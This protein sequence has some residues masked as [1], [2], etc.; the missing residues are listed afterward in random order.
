MPILCIKDDQGKF[1]PVP[2]LKGDP[3]VYV[4]ST[5]PTGDETIWIDPE[6][7]PYF[8][9][10]SADTL[11]GVK[12]GKGLRMDGDAIEVVQE[13]L[14]I[15]ES[16]EVPEGNEVKGYTYRG[17]LKDFELTV[18]IPAASATSG[19]G[20]EVYKGNRKICGYSYMGTLLSTKPT[21]LVANT[22]QVNGKSSFETLF[23][24]H[25]NSASSKALVNP[26][27]RSAIRT[28]IDD[29][30]TSVTIYANAAFPVGTKFTLRGV[31]TD[32]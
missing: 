26:L 24:A 30:Y 7:E 14:E 19:G 31:R 10:A 3:G 12:V 15:I 32:A 2:A 17:K 13:E 1:I 4:G 16:V 11:G 23:R 22:A 5:P 27:N 9:V 20:I 29:P 6:G 8:P 21:L 25:D 28:D 18:D